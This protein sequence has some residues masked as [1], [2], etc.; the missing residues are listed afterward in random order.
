MSIRPKKHLGQHFLINEE[1]CRNIAEAV[2][3]AQQYPV[4]EIGSGT[5]ALTKFLLRLNLPLTL[6][7]YDSEA[8]EYLR[9][10]YPSAL[11]IIHDDILKADWH[12]FGNQYILTGNLPYNISTQVLF[13][14]F[15]NR[16]RVARCVF[17]LQQEVAE[18]IVSPPGSRQYGI[19]SVLL[20]AFYKMELLFSLTPSDFY[21]PPRVHSSVIR[22]SRNEV[23]KLNCDERRF[24]LLVKTAFNQR[25]KKLSNALKSLI[26]DWPAEA[27]FSNRRAEE[28]SWQDFEILTVLTEKK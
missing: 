6:V 13:K 8:I 20:Q 4:I 24:I 27:N 15:E 3:A 21:P 11:H 22:M 5:G 16:N 7:E 9:K 12:Q 26:T 1:A 23:I 2:P 10:N 25:R 18:R 19:L 17:M 14:V 28:L